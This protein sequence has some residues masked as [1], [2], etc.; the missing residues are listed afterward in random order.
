M[1]HSQGCQASQSPRDKPPVENLEIAEILDDVVILPA[2]KGNAT[3]V[4][5]RTS[6]EMFNILQLPGRAV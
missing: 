4:T 3:V 1:Q 6:I 2:D 5:E